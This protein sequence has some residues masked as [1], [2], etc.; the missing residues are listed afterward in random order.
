MRASARHPEGALAQPSPRRPVASPSPEHQRLLDL[1]RAAGNQAVV[2]LAAK[3]KTAVTPE[4][5]A[6]L[7]DRIAKAAHDVVGTPA[8]ADLFRVIA[9]QVKRTSPKATAPK[10][11]ADDPLA[12]L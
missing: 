4:E 7:T 2:Q 5:L 1:Q 9:E 10:H 6:A 3:A 8:A 11:K 12:D